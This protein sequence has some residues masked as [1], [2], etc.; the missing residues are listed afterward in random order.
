MDPPARCFLVFV[1]A[2]FDSAIENILENVDSISKRIAGIRPYALIF[3][4]KY[5]NSLHTSEKYPMVS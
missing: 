4:S 5:K 3:E 1:G 2:K